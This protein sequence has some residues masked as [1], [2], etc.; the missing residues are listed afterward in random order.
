MKSV[1]AHHVPLLRIF[2]L[3]LLATGFALP[4]QSGVLFAKDNL[5]DNQLFLPY[6]TNRFPVQNIFGVTMYQLND[7]NGIG[8]LAEGRTT[9]T[10]REIRW[11]EIE[12]VEGQRNW[13]PSFEQELLNATQHNI[14]TVLI[15]E[16]TP[17]WALKPGYSCGA[18][19]R[20]KFEALGNFVFDLVQRYSSEPFGIE[21]FELWNE[22]DVV[23]KLGCWGDPSD[24]E[25]L[26]GPITAKC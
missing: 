14:R 18:V 20:N 3:G 10:R 12:P 5:Q 11:A 25:Y 24:E 9:W 1:I 22:P 15:I 21:Y 23:D 13:S 19:D 7:A 2:I 26:V 6:I 4:Q 16:N 8:K 17:S